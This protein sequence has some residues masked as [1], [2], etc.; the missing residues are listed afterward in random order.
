MGAV[1]PR[2]ATIPLYNLRLYNFV[3]EKA[4]MRVYHPSKQSVR[5]LIKE[6]STKQYQHTGITMYT[7][8]LQSLKVNR[9]E[10]SITRRHMPEI[11]G[12][13]LQSRTRKTEEIAVGANS[14][15]W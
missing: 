4:E 11:E 2:F 5:N 12:T 6:E 9:Q 10:E 15:H 1:S 8:I 7:K 13:S 3:F 14:W